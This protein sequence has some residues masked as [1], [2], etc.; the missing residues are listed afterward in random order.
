MTWGGARALPRAPLLSE[1]HPT[2][3]IACPH[4]GEGARATHFALI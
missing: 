3:G 2:E 1:V 4:A